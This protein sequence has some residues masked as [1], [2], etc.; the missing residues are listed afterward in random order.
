M[1]PA[2]SASYPIHNAQAN[3]ETS[4]NLLCRL[5]RLSD[6]SG[7]FFRQFRHWVSRSPVPTA[8]AFFYGVVV[9][10]LSGPQ[11]KMIGVYAGRIVALMTDHEASRDV[12]VLN[13]PHQSMSVAGFW[14]RKYSVSSW[15]TGP[16]PQ[17]AGRGFFN[18]TKKTTEVLCHSRNLSTE[19]RAA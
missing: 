5:L 17:P 3:S 4:G 2:L 10:V 7:L 14:M 13:D 6:C 16:H 1:I 19:R 12:S 15:K 8:S 18:A 11:K 9:V